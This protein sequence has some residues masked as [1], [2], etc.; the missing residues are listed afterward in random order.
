[1]CAPTSVTTLHAV[2]TSSVVQAYLAS[3][4]L[5]VVAV[6]SAVSLAFKKQILGLFRGSLSLGFMKT[7]FSRVVSRLR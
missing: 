7:L 3:Q 5:S 4:V 2:L 6:A 1:M